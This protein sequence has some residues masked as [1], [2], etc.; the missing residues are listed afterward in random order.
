MPSGALSPSELFGLIS[1]AAPNMSVEDRRTMVAISLAESDGQLGA[2]NTGNSN[3]TWDAG[4]W[5]VNEI[6]GFDQNRLRTDAQYSA[7]A[8]AQV[9]AKQGLKAWSVFKSGK[10]KQFMSQSAGLKAADAPPKSP[11]FGSTVTAGRKSRDTFA[12]NALSMLPKLQSPKV[13]TNRTLPTANK[14]VRSTFPGSKFRPNGTAVLTPASASEV[15]VQ[16]FGDAEPVAVENPWGVG[17][18]AY[19]PGT[20]TI[21]TV[22]EAVADVDRIFDRYSSAYGASQD[23][24]SGG[25]GE[26]VDGLTAG[27]GPKAPNGPMA[28]GTGMVADILNAARGLLG[29]PYVWGGTTASGVDC[30]GLIYYAFNAAGFKINR[31]RAVDYGKR[32]GHSVSLQDARPGDIVYW[33]NPGD[34]D[35][36]GIYL[37]NGQYIQAPTTGDVVK[38]SSLSARPPT[39]IRRVLPE[40]AWS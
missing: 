11:D 31:Y 32:V 27:G 15:A 34:V 23:A 4:P 26:S 29:K 18:K 38:I 20:L 1:S 35:H 37:G 13:A 28:S 5:Q 36:V 17:P 19:E 22:D 2:L 25:S 16:G 9:F 21:P 6:H 39:S 14:A 33:D 3:G 7:M 30:S 24:P 12:Q 8:A 40:S 10:Y